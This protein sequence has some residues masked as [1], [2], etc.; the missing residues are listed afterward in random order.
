M[1][2]S[3]SSSLSSSRVSRWSEFETD[4]DEW[5]GTMGTP[6]SPSTVLTLSFPPGG[7]TTTLG[8]PEG[9]PGVGDG[10]SSRVLASAPADDDPVP[11]PAPRSSNICSSSATLMRS[12]FASARETA[13]RRSFSKFQVHSS[14]LSGAAKGDKPTCRVMHVP[15]VGV[16]PSHFFFLPCQSRETGQWGSTLRRRKTESADEASPSGAPYT[17]KPDRS[18]TYADN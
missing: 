16:T 14:Y 8:P 12:A 6:M 18:R 13:L 17:P 2:R 15:H 5:D 4:D 10:D 11:M 9:G 7:S 3:R 1:I